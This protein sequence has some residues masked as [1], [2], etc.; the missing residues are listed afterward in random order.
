MAL[1][2]APDAEVLKCHKASG[3]MKRTRLV[4]FQPG[5]CATEMWNVKC[6]FQC[7]GS[8]RAS[9]RPWWSD[10]E[11]GPW[12][13][14]LIHWHVGTIFAP[15]QLGF[16]QCGSSKFLHP[17]KENQGPEKD[18]RPLAR[19]LVSRPATLPLL[20]LM[21]GRTFFMFCCGAS[22]GLEN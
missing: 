15:S 13:K 20:R 21:L 18:E 2:W 7:L 1:M 9:K 11:F 8:V 10:L 5:R 3:F 17:E 19:N 12:K 6:K 22:L 14:G 16:Q 4:M